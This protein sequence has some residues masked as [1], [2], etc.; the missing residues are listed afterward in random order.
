MTIGCTAK[1]HGST[2]AYRKR[3]CRCDEAIAAV[4]AESQRIAARRPRARRGKWSTT[5]KDY[6]EVKVI[7]ALDGDLSLRL[8]TAELADAIAKLDRRRWSAAEI[9]ERLG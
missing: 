8:T 9:A 6:D 4:Q 7:R 3:G 2:W 1:S 5:W